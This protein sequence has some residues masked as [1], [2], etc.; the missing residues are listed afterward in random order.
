MRDALATARGRG[1]RVALV[2]TM[3]NLHRGHLALV[4]RA[5]EQAD[6]VVVSIFVNPLQFGPAD[7][8]AR[9]P[10]TLEAD[11][12]KLESTGIS[13]L[14]HPGVEEMYPG[15]QEAATWVEVPRISQE[16]CGR[17]RPG[18]FRGVATVV[19]KL[20]NIVQPDL[21]VFGEKDFQQLLL[22]RRMVTDLAMPVR[23]IGVPTVREADG[24]AMSSRNAYLSP[25]ERKIAP[26]LYRVLSDAATRIGTGD[27]DYT[28]LEGRVA[29]R[30]EAAGFRPDYVSVRRADTLTVPE[31]GDLHLVLLVAAW[32]GITR[33][34]D[35]RSLLLQV[36][37]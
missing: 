19:N 6:C 5:A 24:L 12:E 10:R 28:G 20:F 18:H 2:P 27:R 36:D 29:Q 14:F 30:L 26:M 9:Y 21:A 32:L 13:Y 35:N 7:D 34:I 31:A 23:I 16:L 25:E 1:A 17:S 22:I 33:L 15:G 11:V 37:D 3:G 4:E 8:Y